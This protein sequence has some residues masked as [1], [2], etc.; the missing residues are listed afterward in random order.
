[1]ANGAAFFLECLWA[2][3]DHVAVENPIMHKHAVAL[4]GGLRASQIVQPW[5][6]GHSESKA[7]LLWLRGLPPLMAT[8]LTTGRSNRS[9]NLA[10]GPERANQRALTFAGIAEAM[11]DQWG[12]FVCRRLPGAQ[13]TR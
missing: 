5:Q 13:N 12:D 8:C 7:A 6:H 4:L 10:P 3:S 2:N 9:N 11:A 1:M